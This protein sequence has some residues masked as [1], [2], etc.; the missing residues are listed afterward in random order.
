MCFCLGLGDSADD[1]VQEP[2]VLRTQKRRAKNGKHLHSHT[3]G[4]I[5]VRARRNRTQHH[6]F[7]LIKADL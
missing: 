1:A 4:T 6:L 7:R 5:S 3:A 2:K